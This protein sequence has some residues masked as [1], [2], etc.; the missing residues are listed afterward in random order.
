[1]KSLIESVLGTKIVSGLNNDRTPNN[2][3]LTTDTGETYFLKTGPPGFF[4]YCEAEGLKEIESC[5]EINTPPVIAVSDNFIL[6]RYILKGEVTPQFFCNM[7]RS[8][9][10]MHKHYA[11]EYGFRSN[12][13]IGTNP[14]INIARENEKH[15]WSEFFFNNRILFQ[16]MMAEKKGLLSQPFIERF[17]KAENNINNILEEVAEAPS[18][19]HGDLWSGNYIC[20]INNS[21]YL[22]DCAVYY[23]HRETDL[24]MTKIFGGFSAD[25]YRCYNNEFPLQPGWQKRERIYKLYHILNH[26]NIFGNSYMNEAE[27]LINYYICESNY[28]L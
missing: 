1:M 6:T 20:G 11:T 15:S 3:V 23:G 9:A 26:L 2:S 18:L 19:L 24:A 28:F 16:Y 4:F 27:N 7:G 10:R 5:K 13:Y 14:Q 21:P 17:R 12:N 22:I 25:F 8:L